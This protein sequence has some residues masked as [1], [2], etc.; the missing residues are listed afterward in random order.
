MKHLM[1][2]LLC[3]CGLSVA[4]WSQEGLLKVGESDAKGAA[5]AKVV[6]EYPQ[7]AKQM[8]LAGR[9]EV[10]VVIDADGNV[11]KTQVVTGNALLSS[12]ATSALKKWKFTPFNSGGKPCRAV[13]TIGFDF[14]L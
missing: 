2:T 14:K 13:T 10:E 5:I 9:V 3:V 6:P 7:M 12:A 8:R 11:E 1:A 4:A